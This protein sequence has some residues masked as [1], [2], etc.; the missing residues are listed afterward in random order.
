[1]RLKSEFESLRKR[2]RFSEPISFAAELHIIS[3]L[4]LE[5]LYE[6]CNVL[7]CWWRSPFQGRAPGRAAKIRVALRWRYFSK[8]SV[9]FRHHDRTHPSRGIFLKRIAG[10]ATYIPGSVLASGIRK[11]WSGVKRI[12]RFWEI[13]IFVI[14]FSHFLT[15]MLK[16][17]FPCRC[18]TLRA[19]KAIRV[20]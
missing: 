19:R 5:R 1:M 12:H 8:N 11:K 15:S 10:H 20:I 3:T 16:L 9:I 17:N 14:I 2:G 6:S 7:L 13:F 18:I 4:R